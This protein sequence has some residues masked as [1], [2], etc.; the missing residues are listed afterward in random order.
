MRARS[1]CGDLETRTPKCRLPALRES[2]RRSRSTDRRAAAQ[3]FGRCWVVF[4]R[5]LLNKTAAPGLDRVNDQKTGPRRARPVP[6]PPGR[7]IRR[8]PGS[9]NSRTH[10]VNVSHSGASRQ[11]SHLIGGRIGGNL[12]TIHEHPETQN[13]CAATTDGTS[14]GSR[15]DRMVQGV[16]YQLGV[17]G[18]RGERRPPPARPARDP[19]SVA[20]RGRLASHLYSRQR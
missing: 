20:P 6:N 4:G 19:R 2:S 8:S 11:Q 5:R 7:P 3:G 14:P 1:S 10:A 9:A 16:H 13:G 12:E 15:I 17:E 18:E